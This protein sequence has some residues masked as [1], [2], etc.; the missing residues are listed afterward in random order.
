M[1]EMNLLGTGIFLEALYTTDVDRSSKL[2][3]Y[4]DR[5]VGV[6]AVHTDAGAT[7]LPRVHV[8]IVGET[9]RAANFSLYAVSA[10]VRK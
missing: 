1:K 2:L 10:V 9:A 3:K 5:N 6:D 4:V 7:G 8:L